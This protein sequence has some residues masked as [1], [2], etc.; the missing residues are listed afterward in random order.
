MA[1]YNQGEIL[2]RIKST[3]LEEIPDA[4]V[5]LFGSRVTGKL[6]EESDWDILILTH[7]IADRSLRKKIHYKLFPFNLKI[8]GIID[9]TIVNEN[10]WHDDP[11]Y[12]VLKLA[13]KDEQVLL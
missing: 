1:M 2:A 4:K 8:N 7:K 9:A 5:Y 13:I 3:V 12:Y 10:D 6:H 11:S